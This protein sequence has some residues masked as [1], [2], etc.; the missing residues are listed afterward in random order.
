MYLF[1]C[2]KMPHF[3][4]RRSCPWSSISYA[5][6]LLGVGKGVGTASVFSGARQTWSQSQ[7]LLAGLWPSKF[8][9]SSLGFLIQLE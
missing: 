5:L 7:H 6:W 8:T 4:G 1:Y 2:V 9:H 3:G